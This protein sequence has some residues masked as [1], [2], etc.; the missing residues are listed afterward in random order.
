MDFKIDKCLL[1]FVILVM[2]SCGRPI[3]DFS[4]SGANEAPAH[5][6]FENKSK[7]AE[8]YEWDFG[9]GNKSLDTAPSH[10]YTNSGNYTVVLK[11]RKGKKTVTKKK[12]L[13]VNSP[14]KCYVE[15][16]T[17]Y[18]NMLIHLYDATP[19]HRDNF[20]KLVEEGFY[21]D[22]LFH[23]VI[24]GFMIQGGDPDSRNAKPNGP[25]G[26]G[27]PG[28]QIPAE[29]VD[30]LIHVK[31]ALAAARNNNPEKKSSGS[32]FYIVQGRKVTDRELGL[33]EAR[34]D[35]NYSSAQ[36]DIYAELG[37]APQLDRGYTVFGMVVEGLEVIDKI[38]AVKTKPGD[39]PLEDVKMKMK[40]IR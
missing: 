18:G 37:G 31:G 6:D 13:L 20:I 14:E 28:Y 19:Q 30:S 23:R 2:L 1:L 29:F 38:A 22:L 32:Q 35:F 10:R 9:D 7:E 17:N 39:R 15:I 4:Y 26:G 25:L 12:Q 34:E 40:V 8:T 24:Q 11:V 21:E 16:Q 33:V 27:G 36:K 3:A 5:V